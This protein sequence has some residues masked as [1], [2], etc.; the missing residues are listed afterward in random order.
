MFSV[1]LL[2]LLAAGSC[3]SH[4][5]RDTDSMITAHCSLLLHWFNTQH[6]FLHRCELWTVDP[7]SLCDCAARST[8][9]HH[10][11]GL[12]FSQQLLHSLD[13]TAC[14][15]RT[16][17]DWDETYWSFILQRFPEE[18]VQYR[19]RD[20]QQHSDSKW[21]E[22]AAWR[23]CCVLLCQ[24]ATVTQTISRP[25]QKPLRAWTL[26]TWSHQRRSPQTTNGFNTSTQPALLLDFKLFG[27]SITDHC[28]FFHNKNWITCLHC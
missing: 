18:Q 26:V 27:V 14:R 16:G 9:D 28:L 25:E 10:L 23:H 8:S 15:E 12:L 2:L 13:Q 19:L 3:E 6:V 1:A 20:F 7:A 11:S 21:T 22:C 17:L 5:G 24:R 4:W